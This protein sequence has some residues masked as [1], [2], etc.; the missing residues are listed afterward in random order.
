MKTYVIYDDEGIN[1]V[2]STYDVSDLDANKVH[3]KY[4]KEVDNGFNPFYY[5]I[6][7]KELVLKEQSELIL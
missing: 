4:F 1:L 2:V 3:G 6:V 5:K 7:D